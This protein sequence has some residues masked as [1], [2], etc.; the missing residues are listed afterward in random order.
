MLLKKSCP[1]FPLK[2]LKKKILKFSLNIPCIIHNMAKQFVDKSSE[3]LL[4]HTYDSISDIK[5]IEYGLR[6]LIIKDIPASE[7]LESIMDYILL[8]KSKP[9]GS[10]QQLNFNEVDPKD[11]DKTDMAIE[12]QKKFAEEMLKVLLQKLMSFS[13]EINELINKIVIVIKDKN[14]SD[15]DKIREIKMILL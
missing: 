10:E 7:K 2:K 4:I 6:C 11:L 9:Y 12:Y 3:N 8:V 14:L 5:K 1:T 15:N 13:H